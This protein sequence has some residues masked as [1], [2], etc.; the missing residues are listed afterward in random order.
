MPSLS[1]T[2]AR[3]LPP[4][5]L[6]VVVLGSV[7]PVHL[8]LTLALP[9]W[10]HGGA[11][12]HVP[13]GLMLV[14]FWA[15]YRPDLLGVGAVF[16]AGC[17]FDTLTGLPLGLTAISWVAIRWIALELRRFL[18][19]EP[20]ALLWGGLAAAASLN[21]LIAW[22]A[23]SLFAGQMLPPTPLAGEVMLAIALFPPLAFVLIRLTRR[24]PE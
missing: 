19:A 4:L 16:L 1:L 12:L 24:L 15:V 22:A 3:V 2:F 8:P 17:L 23:Q 10:P 6:I 7:V 9:G 21:A 18:A 13:L 5:L 14:Y 11:S 20:F